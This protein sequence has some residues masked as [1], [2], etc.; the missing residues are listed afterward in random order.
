MIGDRTIHVSTASE[1]LYDAVTSGHGAPT[2]S[3]ERPTQIYT[4]ID[5]GRE[6]SWWGGVWH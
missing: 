1:L 4:D 3:P 6:Y 2:H 5:T